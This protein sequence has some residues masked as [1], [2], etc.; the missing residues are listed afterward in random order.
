GTGRFTERL[1]EAGCRVTCVEPGANLV[2]V[3]RRKFGDEIE[4][5]VSPWTASLVSPRHFSAVFSAQ[6]FHWVGP[7]GFGAVA[8]ALK[9]EG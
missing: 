6:A 3:A 4:F 9:P 2:E 1:W 8:E 7:A 5:V